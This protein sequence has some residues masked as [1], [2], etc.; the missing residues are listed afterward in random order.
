VSV[1]ETIVGL[2]PTVQARAKAV[3]DF[4]TSTTGKVISAVVLVLAI[5][6]YVHYLGVES[7]KGKIESLTKELGVVKLQ[8][9]AAQQKTQV[10]PEQKAEATPPKAGWLDEQAKAA[11]ALNSKVNSYEQELAKRPA[12]SGDRLSAAESRRLLDIR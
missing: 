12:R 8:L 1:I 10:C 3:L 4:L 9:A 5:L 11:A 2:V 7:Q 6:G